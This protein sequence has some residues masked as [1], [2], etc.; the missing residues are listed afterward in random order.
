MENTVS[1]VVASRTRRH[2]PEWNSRQEC[3]A[4]DLMKGIG[5]PCDGE[6]HARFDEGAMEKYRVQGGSTGLQAAD[7]GG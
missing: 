6:R 7:G 5:K 4:C 1:D 3:A 2:T